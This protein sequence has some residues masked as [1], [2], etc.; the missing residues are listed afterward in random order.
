MELTDLEEVLSLIARGSFES[1]EITETGVPEWDRV[2][3]RE[4]ALNT[5]KHAGSSSTRVATR[6]AGNDFAWNTHVSRG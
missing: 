3:R 5:S 2:E 4:A 6:R 1:E